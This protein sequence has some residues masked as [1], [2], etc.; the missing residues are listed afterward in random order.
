[1]SLVSTPIAVAD[2]TATVFDLP[3][4]CT[5]ISVAVVFYS[6]AG[7]LAGAEV[8]SGTRDIDVSRV[9]FAEGGVGALTL[10]IVGAT[11][12]AHPGSSWLAFA[13]GTPTGR[14]SIACPAATTPGSATHYRIWVA[15]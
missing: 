12:N 13:L 5:A 10:P 7:A 11:V 1:M 14:V 3:V 2:A 9:E 4:P 8:A 15:S 6:T